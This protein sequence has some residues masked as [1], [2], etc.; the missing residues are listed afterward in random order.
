MII[1]IMKEISLKDSCKEQANSFSQM[2]KFI[3]DHG[4]NLECMAKVVSSIQMAKNI[5]VK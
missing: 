2:E 3:L 1:A 5:L 4:T